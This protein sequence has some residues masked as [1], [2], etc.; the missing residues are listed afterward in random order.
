MTR[1]AAVME[2]LTHPQVK[3]NPKYWRAWRD[4][5]IPPDWQ[6]ISWVAADNMLARDDE[7]HTRLRKL[8]SKA[9]TPRRVQGM[10]DR[11][12]EIVEGL[13]DGMEAGDGTADI[14]A[15][16]ALPLPMTVISDLFG[17]E[18]E[19]ARA[20]LHRRI[21]M[22]FDQSITPEQAY[23][24]HVGTQRF[25]TELVARK[26]AEPGDDMTS[27]LIAARDADND[28]LS[29]SE[30]V[31]TL[32]LIIGAGYET[33]MNLLTNTVQALLT[34]RDQL[35]MVLRGEREW[36]DAVEETLRWNTSIQSVPLRYAAADIEIDGTV[37]PEGDALLV[38]YGS[39]GRDRLLHAEGA[40]RFDIT[41]E[42][43]TH[44]SFSHGA[45]YCLGANLAQMELAVAL[46]ALWK[47]FPGLELLEADPEQVPS[48]VSNGVTS[49]RVR[50]G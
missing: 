44:V 21:G 34:H 4:G 40:D 24:N 10:Q 23:E 15:Q 31:W 38:S 45:H 30:L 32:I 27:A 49:L 46:P 48:I 28:R 14:K 25:L 33:T 20:E 41:R 42:D 47:R 19:S 1:H 7:D 36:S 11:I 37:V 8:V 43:K 13:L 39:A 29:E 50:L 9:F 17:V 2:V 22:M 3:K 35:D 5:E 12:A 26:R 6:L 18:E 16:L